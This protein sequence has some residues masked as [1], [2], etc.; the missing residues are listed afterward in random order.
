MRDFVM[1]KL[2][3]IELLDCTFRDGGYYNNWNFPREVVQEQINILSQ[4][5]INYCEMGYRKLAESTRGE[6]Y[7]TSE[8]YLSS[9]QKPEGFNYVVMCDAGDLIGAAE[10]GELGVLVKECAAISNIDLL[11]IAVHYSALP[12]LKGSI[13][14]LVACGYRVALNLMQISERTDEEILAF[15][16]YCNYHN[17]SIA[18]FADSFGALSPRRLNEI[19]SIFNEQYDG[20]FGVHLH[21][22]LGTALQNSCLAVEK[23]AKFIDCSVTGMGRGAG[24][25]ILEECLVSLSECNASLPG[26]V[27]L[28][29][30]IE[31]YYAPLKQGNGWGKNHLY[32][33]SGMYSIHP[34]YVQV[35]NQ[36]M[37]CGYTK[38]MQILLALS[39]RPEKQKFDEIILDKLIR[40]LE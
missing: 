18:Y 17:V 31:K 9:F 29:R 19:S 33:L 14:Q 6:Q 30:L 1:D 39:S 20:D 2:R 4:I 36:N 40:E 24:N 25:T 32:F 23:G 11:R 16:K 34:T 26:S 35:L 5:G 22:N 13:R 28:A 8:D 21:D 3:N 37:Q 12:E 7:N 27:A 15:I 38:E 10:L